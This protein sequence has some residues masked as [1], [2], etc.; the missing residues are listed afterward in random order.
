MSGFLFLNYIKKLENNR[1]I[2]KQ[3]AKL[4]K[5]FGSGERMEKRVE[6]SLP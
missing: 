3:S 4:V 1:V 6:F 5:F 2:C